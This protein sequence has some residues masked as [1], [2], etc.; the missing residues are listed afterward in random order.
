MLNLFPFS[1]WLSDKLNRT[2]GDVEPIQPFEQ[3][4]EPGI[5]CLD[6]NNLHSELNIDQNTEPPS[7]PNPTYPNSV[8]LSWPLEE[9]STQMID[10]S[11][12]RASPEQLVRQHFTC[13][14]CGE[15]FPSQGRLSAHNR[16][17]EKRHHCTYCERQFAESRDLRRHVQSVHEAHCIQCPQCGKEL[18]SRGD[19]L[20]RHIR[21]YCKNKQPSSNI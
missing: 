2:D 17:H 5:T 13:N 11:L 7:L 18:G 15:S 10:I 6:Q 4:V 12:E 19:N 20:Q 3:L 9:Q 16:R 14:K 21:Q 8:F 1:S